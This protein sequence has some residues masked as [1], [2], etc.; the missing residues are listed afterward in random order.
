MLYVIVIVVTLFGLLY[1]YFT[2]T[3][4]YWKK[5]G[6]AGPK[7]VAL[8]GNLKDATLRREHVTLTLKKIYDEFP[9]EKAIGIY[10]LTTPCL[11]LRDV[12]LI[13]QVMIKDFEV[14]ADR[15]IEFSDSGLGANIFHADG[16]RWRILRTKFTPLFT[17]GKLKNMLYLINERGDMFMDYVESI[18]KNQPE[19]SVHLLLQKYTMST[20]SACAFG[21]DLDENMIKTLQKIDKLVLTP[22]YSH[23]LDMMYPGILKKMN[24]S[25]FPSFVK[26]FFDNL[27][28]TVIEQRGGQPTNRK[29]FM[30][31]ILELRQNKEVKGAKRQEGEE[32]K[33]FELT[34]SIIAAQAFVFYVAGY[35]TSATTMSYLLYELAKN[36][37]IQDK[38]VA[39]IDEVLQRHKSEL[40]YE[41]LK[42]VNYFDRVFDETLRKYPIVEPLQRRAQKNY[43][44]PDT[45]ITVE[46]GQLVLISCRSLHHNPKYYPDPEKFDPERFSPQNEKNIPSCAY[47]PF[48]T[49]PRNCL[50]M[51]FAKLQTRVAIVKLLSK[52]RVEPSKNTKFDMN[53]DPMRLVVFPVGG[54]YLNFI[55]R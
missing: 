6:V 32:I 9:N 37:D 48:G 44:F 12:D 40:T 50:G 29:D 28:Q 39:Q 34:E 27:A 52:F 24:S 21:V 45:N 14:F 11:L 22:N 46:K 35:E 17:S 18:C 16:E 51:R 2:R 53:F 30:D 41:I 5:R 38:L 3:F 47:L 26:T 55:R 4:N 42:E 33:S 43:T 49:G 7:P 15:G 25:L 23:E 13:K 20:I 36:P 31:L 1:S 10:R 8:F 19:Q 54:I